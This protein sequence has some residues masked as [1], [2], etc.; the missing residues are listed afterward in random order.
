MDKQPNTFGQPGAMNNDPTNQADLFADGRSISDAK[1][2]GKKKDDAA[3]ADDKSN[4]L[5]QKA[6]EEQDD[7][8]LAEDF[9]PFN[10]D[11]ID[12]KNNDKD[13]E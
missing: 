5:E 13:K 2:K 6:R 1:N 7:N 8:P 10:L 12:E 3:Y 9:E 4:E 11:A